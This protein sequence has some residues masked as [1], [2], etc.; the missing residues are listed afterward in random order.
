M[1]LFR[2]IL[3]RHALAVAA[4]SLHATAGKPALSAANRITRRGYRPLLFVCAL[5]SCLLALA[6]PVSAKTA[7]QAYVEAMQ[8]G[9]NIGNTLDATPNETAWGNPL[10]TQEFIQQI[11]AQGFKSI[12]I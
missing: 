2:S 8:P 3:P 4:F 9:Y 12:R 7:M 5:V 6:S 11:K 10:V 1:S